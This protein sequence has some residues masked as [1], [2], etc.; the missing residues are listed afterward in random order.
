MASE[1]VVLRHPKLFSKDAVAMSRSRME[2][3]GG[4]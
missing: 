2:E 3:W 4:A 1:A